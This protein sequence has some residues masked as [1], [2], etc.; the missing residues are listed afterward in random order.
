MR[1]RVFTLICVFRFTVDSV[2]LLK[3]W[4]V[5]VGGVHLCQR[6][7][8][9]AAGARIQYANHDRRYC[10]VS[11]PAISGF[12]NFCLLSFCGEHNNSLKVSIL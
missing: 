1:A 9:T 8:V 4:R 7:R 5:G 12:G 11:Q 2:N 6:M 3:T 10:T